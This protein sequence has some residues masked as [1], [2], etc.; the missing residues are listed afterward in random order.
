MTGSSPISRKPPDEINLL[1]SLIVFCCGFS[2]PFLLPEVLWMV[3][4]YCS[5]GFS[6]WRWW[7][8]VLNGDSMGKVDG[9]FLSLESQWGCIETGP[10]VMG[11]WWGY[12][13]ITLQG[14]TSA[15]VITSLFPLFQLSSLRKATRKLLMLRQ[16]MLLKWPRSRNWVSSISHPLIIH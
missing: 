4:Y 5:L 10:F 7:T 1:W 3:F 16:G 12:N 8:G 13:W 15:A 9:W 14:W 2:N 6:W 11:P